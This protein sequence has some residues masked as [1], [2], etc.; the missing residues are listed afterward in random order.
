MIRAEIAEHEAEKHFQGSYD[1]ASERKH[2]HFQA[3][4]SAK[5]VHLCQV[6]GAAHHPLPHEAS[7]RQQEVP[8]QQGEHTEHHA[9]NIPHA[10]TM[11]H[12]SNSM[13]SSL[14]PALEI[15]LRGEPLE[16]LPVVGNQLARQPGLPDSPLLRSTGHFGVAPTI[17]SDGYFGP[18]SHSGSQL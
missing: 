3:R 12:M 17:S 9:M 5:L 14:P 2:Q 1:S 11:N 16:S 6:G 15:H 13:L 4:S 8:H 18:Q 7:A 10:A